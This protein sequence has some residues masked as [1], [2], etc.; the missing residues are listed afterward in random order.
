MTTPGGYTIH[1]EQNLK[2]TGSLRLGPS[3]ADT[4]KGDDIKDVVK[5]EEEAKS[6]DR[7]KG[8][9]IDKQQLCIDLLMDGCVQS[10]IDFFYIT[11]RKLSSVQNPLGEDAQDVHIPEET[12]V[13]FKDTLESAETARRMKNYHHCFEHYN[14]LSDYF[15]KMGD[16]KTAMYFY[17]RC[18]EVATEVDARESIAKANLNLGLCEEKQSHWEEAM[19]YHEKALVLANN[20]DSLPLQI[21]SASRLVHVYRTLAEK[22]ETSGQ[23]QNATVFFERCLHCARLSKDSSLE[24]DACHRLGKAKHAIGDYQTAIDLQQQYLEMAKTLDDRAAEAAAR[25]ALAHAY[26][27][28]GQKKEAINQLECLLNVANDAGELQAQVSACLNLGL[29]YHDH[30]SYEKSVELLEQHFDLSRQLGDRKLID[31][32]R[33]ILGMARGHGKLGIYV[34]LINSNL[35]KLL[36]WKSK[37]I[38]LEE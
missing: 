36:Q 33:V 22:C 12:L 29:L 16:L 5:K 35:P 10:F 17:A 31:S 38:A 1:T 20:A 11:H 23:P 18:A 21:K 13:F 4:A 15:E 28:L 2:V 27:A 3:A 19:K 37:R 25:A 8:K 9:G 34:N 24:G 6:A 26:E 14:V 7:I 30:G 32:A